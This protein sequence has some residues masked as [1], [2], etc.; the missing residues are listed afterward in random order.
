MYNKRRVTE[1]YDFYEEE[2]K[3]ECLGK[4]LVL[5]NGI[6]LPPR[7]TENCLV[8]LGCDPRELPKASLGP[9]GFDQV[10]DTEDE[11]G[12]GSTKSDLSS[13]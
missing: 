7:A 8:R 1:R 3:N 2:T 11:E 12:T 10:E 9:E 6:K 4:L 13:R 5:M